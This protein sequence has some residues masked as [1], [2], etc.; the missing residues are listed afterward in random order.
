MNVKAFLA[1]EDGN[2]VSLDAV[3]RSMMRANGCTY[4]EAATVLLRLMLREDYP[5]VWM[6]KSA[7]EGVSAIEA[8]HTVAMK[9][10]RAAAR[11]GEPV[12][13]DDIPF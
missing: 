5:P 4:Q 2:F 8:R 11:D 7:T 12:D 13:A 1:K 6:F 10:L 9:L 3:L